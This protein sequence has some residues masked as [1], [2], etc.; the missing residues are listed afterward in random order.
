MINW[1]NVIFSDFWDLWRCIWW[2]NYSLSPWLRRYEKNSYL[3][4]IL[5]L[6]LKIANYTQG[7]LTIEQY[8]SGF[9]K[10][11]SEYSCIIYANVLVAALQEIDKWDQFLMKLR[12]EFEVAQ[13]S[14]LNHDPIP[15]LD[16][17]FS[18]LLREKQRLTTQTIMEANISSSNVV[19]VAYAAQE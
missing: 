13:A 4:R 6:E 11:W 12:T 3:S 1:R 2:I 8:Y 5:Q 9:L 18:E 19:I 16:V 17:C 14:L 7:N 10:L 15:F